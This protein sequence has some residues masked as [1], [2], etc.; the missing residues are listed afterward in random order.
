VFASTCVLLNQ[1]WNGHKGTF[2]ANPKKTSRVASVD[3]CIKDVVI[4]DRSADCE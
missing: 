3:G 1:K 2:T 4:K